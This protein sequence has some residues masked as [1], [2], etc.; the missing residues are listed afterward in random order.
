[1]PA[2]TAMF[3]ASVSWRNQAVKNTVSGRRSP[4]ASRRESAEVR[5]ALT[6]TTP[7][8]ASTG[9]RDRAMTCQPSAVSRSTRADPAMPVAPATRAVRGVRGVFWS[10]TMRLC[11]VVGAAAGWHADPP[12]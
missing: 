8:R 9:V 12:R 6:G 1:M 2:F 7:G 3:S 4:S 11:P 10:G 5:S